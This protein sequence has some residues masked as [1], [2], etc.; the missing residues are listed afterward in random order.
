MD[1]Q[2]Y[3]RNIAL[4]DD[5]E[6]YIHKKFGRLERHL[7][8]ISDAKLE[9]SQ[10]RSR[11]QGDV[12]VAQL[13][14]SANGQI[15]RG[16]ET[17]VNLF[18]AIDLVTDVMDRQIQRYKTQVYRSSKGR[19]SARTDLKRE[20]EALITPDDS[21]NDDSQITDF[22]SVVRTKRFEMRPM[23]LDDA[24]SEMEFLSHTFFLFYNVDSEEYNVLYKRQD[25]DYGVIQ[26]EL[27][28]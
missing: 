17:G 13:T 14:L 3:A 12:V 20:T 24:I 9:I 2:I 5:S 19:R 4:G 28:A 15:L 22:G 7:N 1:I 27:T 8:S 11:S 23:T 18:A 6:D 26:P 25:G 16:Q 10:K 21:E